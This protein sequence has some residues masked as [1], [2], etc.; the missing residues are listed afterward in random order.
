[1]K[2]INLIPIVLFTFSYSFCQTTSEKFI[3]DFKTQSALLNNNL[4][5]QI[6]DLKTQ[7]ETIDQNIVNAENDQAELLA[8]RDRIKILEKI[9]HRNLE[10]KENVLSE[11]YNSAIINLL[12]LEKDIHPLNLYNA[13]TS[14]HKNLENVSN[15]TN[16]SEYNN[17]L[18]EY[19]KFLDKTRASDILIDMASK[20]INTTGVLS[21]STLNLG[22]ASDI[23]LSSIEKFIQSIGN[24]SG[25]RALREQSAKMFQLL[26]VL[27]NYEREKAM[28]D[29]KFKDLSYELKQL[30]KTQ[31]LALDDVIKTS[32]LKRNLMIKHYFDETDSNENFLYLERVRKHVNNS[33]KNSKLNKK[34]IKHQMYITQSL[35]IRF[36]DLLE[37]MAKNLKDYEKLIQKYKPNKMLNFSPL[38][39]EYKNVEKLFN[40]NFDGEKVKLDAIKMYRTE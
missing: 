17:W 9:E 28:L 20:I 24:S 25:K 13:T 40:K 16:Y 18:V 30:E 3:K 23:I 1:M 36:G 4:E 35:K 31:N 22:P 26:I 27:K 6:I 2:L 12:A 37:D 21:A 15:P 32:G 34:E 8:L 29:G 10:K 11:N 14:F 39:A 33:I 38:E 5:K 7:I 19:K